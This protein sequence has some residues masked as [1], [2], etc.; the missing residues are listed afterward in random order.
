[1]SAKELDLT[2]VNKVADMSL[3][4]FGKKEMQLSE[5]EMPGHFV[6]EGKVEFFSGHNFSRKVWGKN[7]ISP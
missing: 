1:M 7:S 4:D 5:R 2:L 6:D 3:A